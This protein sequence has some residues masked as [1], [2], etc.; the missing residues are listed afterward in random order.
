MLFFYEWRKTPSFKKKKNFYLIAYLHINYLKYIIMHL[1]NIIST[2]SFHALNAVE[3]RKWLS[4]FTNLKIVGYMTFGFK[5]NNSH[6][7]RNEHI[8]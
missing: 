6:Q 5:A 1:K 3:N 7:I 2:Y 4:Y 8:P